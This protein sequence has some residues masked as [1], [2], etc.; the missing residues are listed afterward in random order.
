[1]AD[2]LNVAVVGATGA[3]GEVLLELMAERKFPIADLTLLSSERSA[4]RNLKFN[5][6]DVVVQNLADA[7][8]DSV[9]LVLSSAS[10]SISKKFAKQA[11]ACGAVVVDNTSAFRMDPTVPLVIPEINPQ[12]VEWNSG[13]I[14]NPNCS[15]I[16]MNMAVWP[17][18]YETRVRR[19]V[20]STYQAISGAGAKAMLE[21]DEQTRAVLAGNSPSPRELPHQI[22][23]N[24]FSHDSDIGE[25]GYCEEE[26]KMVRET[27]KIFHDDEIRITATCVRVPVM[28]AHSEAINLEFT[29]PMTA[30]RA[31]EILS[32]APGI[33]IVDDQ[34]GNHFPMPIEA[35]G[36]DE[37]LAGRLR[38]DISRTDGRGIDLFVSG[39]QL[40]KGAA[41]N[42]VQI[43]ELLVAKGF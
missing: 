38:Q 43:A 18:H 27:K 12:D 40:R 34:L 5:G 28:R 16:I 30:V 14:A 7:S 37:V 39:D 31:K 42:A 41:L 26:I 8:F 33:K 36:K 25:E 23:F 35:S 3:V 21:L 1:M 15:T 19:M 2:G 32:D 6:E 20:V 13:I 4:G 22:A 9:D 10:G 29:E 24:L 17:L 11:V